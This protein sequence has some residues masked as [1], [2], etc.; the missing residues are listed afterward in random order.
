MSVNYGLLKGT[1][2]DAIPYNSGADHYQ[3]EVQGGSDA[4]RIAVDVYSEL[5]GSTLRYSATGFNQL[6]T[7]R[8]V[9]YYKDEQYA[10]PIT[11]LMPACAP[12]FTA[13]S[14]LDQK[15]YLDYVRYTPSLFPLDK[16]TVVPPK[17]EGNDDA[18]NPGANNGSNPGANDVSNPGAADADNLNADIDPWIQKAK[19]NPDA[20][21]YAFGSGWDDN[22]PGA[23]P[24]TQTYFN[25]DPSLGIHDIHMNQ[26][27][28]GHEAV[29]NGAWQDG[30]LFI[31]FI[32]TGQWVAM[33]FR[34]QNQSIT[35]DDSGNPA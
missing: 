12:G 1:V 26:G 17:Q 3:I 14:D 11:A 6:D 8:M 18:G 28:T 19:N 24:D 23:S 27:D 33:F 29:N 15:L 7:D 25:P 20:E 31:H 22:A 30:A 4:Y 13:K 32:S 9:M 16:M 35:T 21:I 34:F 10:H 5:A 2:T